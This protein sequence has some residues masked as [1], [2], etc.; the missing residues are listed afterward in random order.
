MDEV[1]RRLGYRFSFSDV[2]HSE[3]SAGADMQVVLRIKNSGF[4]APVNP[5]AVELVF[6]DGNGKK[7]VFELNHIDP[8][9]WFANKTAVINETVKIP[10]DASGL[11]T[12]YLNLPDPKP[13]LHD[14]PDFSIRLANEGVWESETGYNKVFEFEIN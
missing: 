11:C 8:R 10:A 2:Y 9:F 14:N 7:T 12:L 13:T 5:R 4:A 1:K 6:V 3:A